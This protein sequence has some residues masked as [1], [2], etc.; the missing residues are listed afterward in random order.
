MHR[1]TICVA[2]ERQHA[3]PAR[4]IG[5]A[6]KEAAARLGNVQV[7]RAGN[8]LRIAL[9]GFGPGARVELADARG[10]TVWKAEPRGAL[11]LAFD[12]RDAAGGRLAAG[13]YRLIAAEGNLRAT[14]AVPWTP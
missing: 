3:R 14:A 2:L 8:G 9:E 10:R 4:P 7:T 6:R 1:A 5:I 11:S 13:M 12:G